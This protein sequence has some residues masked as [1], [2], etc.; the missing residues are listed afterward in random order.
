MVSPETASETGS[1][2]GTKVRLLDAAAR[3]TPF[4]PASPPLR[5][6]AAAASGAEERAPAA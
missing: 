5:D 3:S 6:A 2:N 1:D 4:P